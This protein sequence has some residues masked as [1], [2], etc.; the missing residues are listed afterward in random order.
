MQTR[1]GLSVAVMMA[2]ALGHVCAGRPRHMRSLVQPFA[3]TG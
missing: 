2:A 3:D 1:I